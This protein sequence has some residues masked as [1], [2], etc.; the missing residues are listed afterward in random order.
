M[1]SPQSPQ[2]QAEVVPSGSDSTPRAVVPAGGSS[3]AGRFVRP[4]VAAA[5]ALVVWGV[6]QTW[7]PFFSPPVVVKPPSRGPTPPSEEEIATAVRYGYLNTIALAACA[8]GL[9]AAAIGLVEGIRRGSARLALPA[10][11]LGAILG[12]AAGAAGG[13]CGQR[14][15]EIGWLHT[16]NTESLG[17][18]PRTVAMQAACWVV[19]GLGV[20]IALAIPLACQFGAV[21]RAA[22]RGAA[23]GLLAAL[24]YPIAA[25]IVGILLPGGDSLGLVPD[26]SVNRFLW[27]EAGA[28]CI[29]MS[30]GAA[31]GSA[32]TAVAQGP[33]PP[34]R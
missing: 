1:S 21:I 31:S 30:V 17:D 25:I 3:Q 4:A 2:G 10:L 20:G 15:T 34:K 16:L 26:V 33:I 13:W 9:V 29:A 5:A 11:V 24:I 19:V 12:A 27:L 28:V 32:S 8:S 23:G 6:V 18:T 14:V 22:A 7:Y